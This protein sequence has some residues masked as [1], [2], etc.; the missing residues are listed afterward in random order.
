MRN[1]IGLRSKV[2]I[3]MEERIAGGMTL[4]LYTA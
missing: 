2:E 1:S 4:A 3:C